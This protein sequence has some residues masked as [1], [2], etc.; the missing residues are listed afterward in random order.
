M[1]VPLE[2]QK[3][4]A[5][6]APRV[7]E[8]LGLGSAALSDGGNFATAAQG[9]KADNAL[10]ADMLPIHGTVDG[11]TA[12]AIPPSMTGLSTN[13]LASVG[14][15]GAWPLVVEVSNTGPLEPWQRSINDGTRR[16]ELRA[17]VVDAAMFGASPTAPAAL[18]SAAIN[19]A[20]FFQARKGGGEVRITKPGIYL[21]ANTNHYPA[22]SYPGLSERDA[23]WWANRRAIWL[24]DD[25]VTLRLGEGV[26]LKVADGENC[27]AIQI[28]QFSLGMAGVGPAI[29]AKSVKNV[30]VT[31]HAWKIDMNGAMQNAA[32]DTKDH[33]A[34]IIVN[35]GSEGVQ[36]SGGKVANSAYYGIGF[37]GT[38]SDAL[39]GFRRCYV[40]DIVIEDC[41]A[42]GFDAKD[43]GTQS[44]DNVM[45][46][47]TV[48]NCGNGGG[49]YLT[50]QAGIDTRG[51]WTVE[52]CT[53][54]CDDDF[55]GERVGFRSQYA[56]DFA[57]SAD[58][59]HFVRCR[60]NGNGKA[61]AGT[62]GFRLTGRNA[63]A[64]DCT[65]VGFSEGFR[66]SAPKHV[67][68]GLT[69]RLCGIA[70]RFF[71]DAGP[72]WDA[73][74]SILRD[75]FIEGCDV[76]WRTDS[77]VSSVQIDGG[78]ITGT[79]TPLVNNGSATHIK[80]VAGFRTSAR[81]LGSFNVGSVGVKTV[82]VAHGLAVTPALSDIQLTLQKA[83]VSDFAATPMVV[84]ADA[85]NVTIEVNVT[86]AS[87]QNLSGNVRVV[88]EALP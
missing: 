23:N 83:S 22:A 68:K 11:L 60:A 20:A 8:Q 6:V 87:A 21:L 15:G 30:R 33:P 84:S 57:Q 4:I 74:N 55:T 36:L 54:Y 27:H 85:T 42:D 7:R 39:K 12:L 88:I 58:P 65:A 34:G 13:G 50:G 79:A 70:Y 66:V 49:V 9:E 14:D 64:D 82:S 28:G 43:F 61:N 77:G 76:G 40:H 5:D 2:R 71:A 78:G 48:R 67:L 59:T 29:P 53:V 24:P 75:S 31:G 63:R 17:S 69:S 35:H 3:N 56:P 81:A 19:T 10:P 25:N 1:T 73:D 47:V 45:S 26:E 44:A 18:N 38:D 37:E 32:T 52:D 86:T 72:A 46:R 51:G 41:K 62:I 16:L 80:G